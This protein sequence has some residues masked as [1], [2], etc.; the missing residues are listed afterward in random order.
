[1]SKWNA[2]S[3][4]LLKPY[5]IV[6]LTHQWQSLVVFVIKRGQLG[7]WETVQYILSTVQ[8]LLTAGSSAL[9]CDDSL[10]LVRLHV[11]VVL[12]RSGAVIRFRA[13]VQPGV[14]RIRVICVSHRRSRRHHLTQDIRGHGTLSTP[15]LGLWNINHTHSHASKHSGHKHT[16]GQ[17]NTRQRSVKFRPNL[18]GMSYVF[19]IVVFLIL[20]QISHWTR[21]CAAVLWHQLHFWNNL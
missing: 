19:W 3:P 7:T 6:T 14:K 21:L 2:L 11:A 18:F 15:V 1:M 5:L 17:S 12:L 8:L 16:L 4:T 9:T 10:C 20:Q 13:P